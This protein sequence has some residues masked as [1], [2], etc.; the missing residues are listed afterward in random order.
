MTTKKV[1]VASSREVVISLAEWEIVQ[2]VRAAQRAVDRR[3]QDRKEKALTLVVRPK[4]KP[5]IFKMQ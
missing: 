2:A 1:Q 4:A 5:R 3:P